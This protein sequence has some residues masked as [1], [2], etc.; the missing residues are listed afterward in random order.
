MLRPLTVLALY[1]RPQAGNEEQGERAFW[2]ELGAEYLT[3][4]VA[5]FHRWL[6]KH[7]QLVLLSDTTYALGH[8]GKCC[9]LI[10]NAPGWWSKVEMFRPSVSQG[11]CLYL[12]LDNVLAGP[13][14][15]LLALNPDPL[16]MADDK[17][18]PGLPNGSVMYFDADRLRFLWNEYAAHRHEIEAEFSETQWPHASD[19]AYVADRV[20][21]AGHDIP[22]LQDLLPPNYLLMAKELEAGATW[23]DTRMVCGQGVPK[24]HQSGHP[25]YEAWK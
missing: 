13:L 1:K 2:A 10:M 16:I 5:A 17:A 11:R 4:F 6:P 20:R 3:K 15:E 24:P 14:D 22:L 21:K 8:R 19:Q 12:D 23:G 9:R 7:A 25:F 18:Y